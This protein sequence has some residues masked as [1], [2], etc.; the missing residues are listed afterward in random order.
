VLAATAG[1]SEVSISPQSSSV[2]LSRNHASIRHATLRRIF[3][4]EHGLR[5]GWSAL[6]FVLIILVLN[7]AVKR[8]ER[9]F[10][11]VLPE[12]PI[13]FGLGML[14]ESIP[15]FLVLLATAVM[16]RIEGRRFLTYGFGGSHRL[17]RLVSGIGWGF[18]A[19]SMLVGILWCSGLLVF[20]GLMLSGFVAWK[21]A[22]AWGLGFLSV[23]LTEE[24]ATR[25]YLQFT[26]TRGVGFW[27]AAVILSL[28]FGVA[29]LS[30][31][32]ES[33]W[34]VAAVALGGFVFCISLWYTKSL[35]WAIGF[36]AGW[37]WAQS[38][39]Y[40]TADSGLKIQNHLLISH[41]SGNPAWSG[42]TVGPEGSLLIL[43]TLM[44]AAFI[45]WLWWGVL[46]KP[47]G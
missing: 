27:W 43:P 3:F 10:I 37:D 17:I 41:P 7:T 22:L 29:H 44:L 30:N 33:H 38:Y 25:G 12:G 45:M 32:G 8:V 24:S 42:G 35:W 4:V 19:L 5:A 20:D 11:P 18:L 36:H 28:L 9:H 13:P 34:G 46:R 6:L 26:L 14:D 2:D 39:F 40:G 21:Y 15:L 31:G 1:E 16:A 23:G 47:S